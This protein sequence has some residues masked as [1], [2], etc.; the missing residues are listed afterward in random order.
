MYGRLSFLFRSSLVVLALLPLALFVYLGQFSRFISDD[1]RNIAAGIEMGPW[2]GMLHWLN[3]W[4]ASY[5]SSF[6]MGFLAPL[7]TWAPRIMPALFSAIWLV[8]LVWL[9]YQG[10]QALPVHQSRLMLSIA[11]SALALAAIINAFYSPQSFYWF[12]SINRYG[13]GVALFTIFVALAIWAGGPARSKREIRWAVLGSALI[14]FLS[15]GISEMH[16]VAQLVFL[17]VCCLFILF[18]WPKTSRGGYLTAFGT[19]WLA[20]VC[21]LLIQLS[22]PSVALR[23][24]ANLD[25]HGA[26]LRELPLL[27][28]E[29]FR[30]TLRFLGNVKAYDGYVLMLALGL[31]LMLHFRPRG[32][33][34]SLRSTGVATSSLLIGL[35][36]QLLLIP[37]IWSHISDTPMIFGRYSR[38]YLL[39]IAS[40]ATLFAVFAGLLWQRERINRRLLQMESGTI[41][42][43]YTLGYLLC[44]TLLVVI[45]HFSH[46]EVRARIYFVVSGLVALA[47]LLRQT[48]NLYQEGPALRLA[49]LA[50]FIPAS[51]LICLVA[52]V[53]VALFGQGFVPTRILEPIA[54][55]LV[56]S[57]L[58][59][60]AFLGYALADNP[61]ANDTGLA[62]IALQKIVCASLLLGVTSSILIGHVSLVP[63]LRI[64]ARD[65]DERHQEI[66]VKRDSGQTVIE[67][68]PLA[69]SLDRHVGKAPLGKEP[70]TSWAQWYYGVDKIIVQVSD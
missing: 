7:D 55:L 30:D 47:I 38:T 37:Y 26:P 31:L 6:L 53:S 49:R 64:Y 63:E 69:V 32:D 50:L 45:I 22:L 35:L 52:L 62:A 27:M 14:C 18:V 67:I 57:G 60:G 20:T 23:S 34:V 21:G 43:C 12:T 3:N 11:V 25:I 36:V 48:I 58:F 16:G 54:A 66:I 19:G 40:N 28:S 8:G 9:V 13:V 10:L 5:T 17:S 41:L 51:A 44:T 70:T 29:T 68:S 46:V 39:V 61:P 1:Y 56:L 4:L 59:C 65:W 24:Q 33:A 2:G 42:A 15:V